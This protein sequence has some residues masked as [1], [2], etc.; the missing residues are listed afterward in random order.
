MNRLYKIVL[1]VF[2]SCQALLSATGVPNTKRLYFIQACPLESR[3]YHFQF[4]VF[5][6]EC[7]YSK[8]RAGLV[9]R[10]TLS[11]PRIG[12]AAID[13]FYNKQLCVVRYSEGY[14]CVDLLKLIDLKK[15]DKVSVV[16]FDYNKYE[17][18][19]YS[20]NKRF[21]YTIPKIGLCLGYFFSKIIMRREA[22]GFGDITMTIAFAMYL[23]PLTIAL[24]LF[25]AAV[26]A[27]LAAL[28]WSALSRKSLNGVR[29]PFGPA[30]ALGAWTTYF[31]G[32]FILQLYLSRVLWF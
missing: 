23:K 27:L 30:L 13:I 4:P 24:S 1:F 12:V 22:L 11:P 2:C 19:D 29:I 28:A 7:R 9:P 5:L 3:D 21:C 17:N 16:R 25:I 20:I 18:Q 26:V 31:F 32:D 6:H 15:M 8:G 14:R 10:H